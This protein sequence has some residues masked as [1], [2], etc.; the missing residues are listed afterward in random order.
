MSLIG[1][2]S[3]KAVG[4]DPVTGTKIVITVL[5]IAGIV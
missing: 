4:M 3:K 2:N 5:K 1:A